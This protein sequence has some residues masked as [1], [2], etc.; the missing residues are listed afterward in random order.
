M[1]P[2]RLLVGIP[3]TL[4]NYQ[5]GKRTALERIDPAIE[6]TQDSQ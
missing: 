4:K 2:D 6:C 1:S 3:L 5:E